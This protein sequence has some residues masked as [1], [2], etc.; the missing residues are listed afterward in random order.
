MSSSNISY[1]TVSPYSFN[2]WSQLNTAATSVLSVDTYNEYIKKWYENNNKASLLSVN[3]IKQD[4]INLLK[5]LTYFF[6]EEEKNLFLKDINFE[7]DIE[8][9]YAIPFFVKKLKE[10]ALT[11]SKKRNIL[12]N[13]KNKYKS[14][15]SYQGIEKLLYE[16]IL[17]SHTKSIYSTQI[18][19]SSLGIKFP[20][21]SAVKDHFSIEIEDLYDSSTYFNIEDDKKT[22]TYIERLADNNLFNILQGF[23]TEIENNT[24]SLSSYSNYT[25]NSTPNY[26]NLI[27]INQK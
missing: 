17:N 9:I 11:I 27:N 24:A 15:G 20:E 8:I 4:Y 16:Y 23:V 6:T 13:N 21:L 19:I 25:S 14:L 2:E 18:S 1:N 12:K 5:E 3:I 10:I 7:D 22:L 26:T